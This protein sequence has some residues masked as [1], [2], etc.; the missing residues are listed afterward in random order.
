VG[1]KNS[2]NMILYPYIYSRVIVVFRTMKDKPITKKVVLFP[3]LYQKMLW[4][5]LFMLVDGM[6]WN[7]RPPYID[8][9]YTSSMEILL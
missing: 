8:N 1:E 5:G 3:N 2:F 4:Y 6:T 7:R 9:P